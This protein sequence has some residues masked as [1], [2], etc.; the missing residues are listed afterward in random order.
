M[1]SLLIYNILSD[2]FYEYIFIQWGEP[3]SAISHCCVKCYLGQS[4]PLNTVGGSG[5][6]QSV[7]HLQT[8][9]LSRP[10]RY[11]NVKREGV[12]FIR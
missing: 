6:Y 7:T 11:A 5:S 1:V 4:A 3:V 10:V 8:T 2:T 9:I 12:L